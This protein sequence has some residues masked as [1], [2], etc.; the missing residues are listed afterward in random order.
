MPSS[1]VIGNFNPLKKN[2]LRKIE[3]KQGDAE[4]GLR[5]QGFEKRLCHS[6]VPAIPFS[7]H[8]AQDSML[9]A[10]LSKGLISVLSSAI[11][12]KNQALMNASLL[13]GHA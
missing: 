9:S 3:L 13:Q 2:A 6:I 11:G 1:A 12:M 8:A 5:F 4:D 10:K 7:A